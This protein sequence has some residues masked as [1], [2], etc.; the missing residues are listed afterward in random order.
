M[1]ELS[2]SAAIHTAKNT[3]AVASLTTSCNRLVIN[4]SISGCVRMA[5]DSLLTSLKSFASCQQTCCKLIVKTCYSQAC[6]KLFKQVVTSLKMTSCNKPG[7]NTLIAR[8]LFRHK[9]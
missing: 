9:F 2:G 6:C 4:K 5:C 3:Q 1:G 8:K 7:F